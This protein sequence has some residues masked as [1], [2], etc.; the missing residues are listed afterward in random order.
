MLADLHRPGDQRKPWSLTAAVLARD[1]ERRGDIAGFLLA[2][3]EVLDSF[4]QSQR[5]KHHSRTV[6]S[7]HQDDAL[8]AL[9]RYY[10]AIDSDI[11]CIK[12][13]TDF[14]AMAGGFHEVLVEF[15]ENR[16]E[17]VCQ[18]NPKVET[19]TNITSGDFGRRMRLLR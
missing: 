19:L 17:L 7:L 18:L 8:D 10:L 2:G 9:I 6:I 11:S 1:A 15:D 3:F 13:F 14:K 16:G 5:G 12:L 4:Q